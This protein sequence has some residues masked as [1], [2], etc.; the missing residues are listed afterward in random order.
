MK[1]VWHRG[2]DITVDAARALLRAME[3]LW[4]DEE[5]REVV[6]ELVISRERR[7]WLRLRASLQAIVARS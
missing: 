6:G 7:C 4:R 5:R 2:P 1:D 3:E